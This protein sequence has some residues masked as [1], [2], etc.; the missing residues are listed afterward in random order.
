MSTKFEIAQDF[1]KTINSDKIKL[2]ILFGSVARG[3]YRP[4]LDIDILIVS[5]YRKDIWLKISN[6]IRDTV[7][8][9]KTV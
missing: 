6:L 1:A 9:R 2:I 5:N 3:D 4:D 8:N 7:L